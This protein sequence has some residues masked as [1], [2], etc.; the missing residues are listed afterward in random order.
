LSSNDRFGLLAD[1]LT[2]HYPDREAPALS[3]FCERID[4]GEVVAIAGPSGCGKTTLCRT[5]AGFLPE[6]VPARVSGRLEIGE[7]SIWRLPPEVLST[8]VGLV[9]QDPDAQICTLNVRQEVAFGPE[10]L[11]LTPGEVARR[12]DE[13]LRGLGI[14]HLVDRT[15]TTLSGGEKQRLA[16]ASILAM[17]PK[18][19]LLDEPTANLDPRGAQ[20]LFRILEALSRQRGMTLIVVEHRID[21]LRG[22]EPRLL[23]LDRGR[24]VERRPSRQRLDYAELGLRGGWGTGIRPECRTSTTRLRL[25][26]LTFGYQA[27]LFSELSFSIDSGEVVG[28]I[29]P[30]GG[31]KTTLLRLLA[32]LERPSSG[33]IDRAARTTIGFAFQHPHHQIFERTVHREVEL[34]RTLSGRELQAN[35]QYARL[36]GLEQAAPLSLSL[37]E[38]R[39]LT[40]LTTLD[41]K[42]NLLL[43]DE[44]FIGQDRANVLWIV[45]RIREE[46]AAG[47]TVI[48]VT[49]DMT[50]AAALAD[51]LLFLDGE[52]FRYGPP[53]EVFGWLRERGDEAFLPETWS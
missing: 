45:E 15:T 51:R 50:L 21:A 7:D 34:G 17:E 23:L 48:L 47:A 9:Q 16:I 32:G 19:L 46:K 53:T 27:P 1:G 3:G 14:S 35:L 10:N 2:V 36:A 29:G 44:P 11:L 25:D 12:V 40:L 31:G 38:Q 52:S 24:L 20:T 42:P 26:R 33:R 49:H 39:R 18:I 6:M 43:L 22:L 30:N 5:L 8:R 13:G 4:E 28:I 37:G 41:L